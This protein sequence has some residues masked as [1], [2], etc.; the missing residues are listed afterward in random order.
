[1]GLFG[2]SNYPPGAENDPRAPWNQKEGPCEVCG[3]DI[4]HCICPECPECGEV[5][6]PSC[7]GRHGLVL[8]DEQRASKER[9]DREAREA[10][11]RLYQWEREQEAL[12]EV[13]RLRA[14]KEAT[15]G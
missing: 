2:Y 14:R 9:A 8:S 5:G 13:E 10:D 7:Y 15:D 11:E 12:C 6:D 1:M 3:L 4:D